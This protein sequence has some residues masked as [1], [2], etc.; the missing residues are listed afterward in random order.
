MITTIR[1][2]TC[3]NN[4]RHTDKLKPEDVHCSSIYKME[5]KTIPQISGVRRK[6]EYKFEVIWDTHQESHSCRT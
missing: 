2:L 3:R 1:T 4:V 6:V 5:N